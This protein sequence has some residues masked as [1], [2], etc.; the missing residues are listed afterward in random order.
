MDA[1]GV[2]RRVDG[3]RHP[4]E[5]RSVVDQYRLALFGATT[6]GTS[7]PIRR[8]EAFGVTLTWIM[9]DGKRF[10]EARQ[11]PMQLHRREIQYELALQT[12]VGRVQDAVVAEHGLRIATAYDDRR[13]A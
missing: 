9:F 1:G 2:L 8:D 3:P 11:L 5:D 10:N 7:E 6:F 4:L 12:A 13:R